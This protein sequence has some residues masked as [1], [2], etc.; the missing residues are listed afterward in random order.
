MKSILILFFLIISASVCLSQVKQIKF[1]D[2]SELLLSE[3][4]MSLSS[5]KPTGRLIKKE[6]AATITGF[7]K[8]REFT[9]LGRLLNKTT[10]EGK[11]IRIS[12]KERKS[13][14]NKLNKITTEYEF[15]QNG[16]KFYS[17]GLSSI[18]NSEIIRDLYPILSKEPERCRVCEVKLKLIMIEMK[19][20]NEI[21]YTPV[22][23]SIERLRTGK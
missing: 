10:K 1:T 23:I 3:N 20:E 7:G 2:G 15:K 4:N 8:A 13:F 6:V 22:I 17:N 14:L 5:M 19:I 18:D 16:G 12:A 11:P 21:Y 9:P